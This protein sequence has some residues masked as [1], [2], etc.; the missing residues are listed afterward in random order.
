M[1]AGR[2]AAGSAKETPV[3]SHRS[4]S[5][6]SLALT[7]VPLAL[8]GCSAAGTDSSKTTN[9]GNGNSSGSGNS[10]S[11]T[12]GSGPGVGMPMLNDDDIN[13]EEMPSTCGQVLPVLYR[14]F[15]AYGQPGGHDDFEAS[16][17]GIHNQ[18]GGIY[19]G[20][21]DVGCGLVEPALGTDG[22]PVAFAGTPD[23]VEAMPVVPAGTGKRRR[24]VS[25]AGC[26]TAANP[27]P[28]GICGIGTCVP[29]DISPITYAIKSSSTFAQWYNTTAGINMEVPGELMLTQDPAAPG[30]SFFD[31]TAFFPIDNKGFGN[32][33]GQQHNYHFTTEIHVKFKYEVGQKFTFR[34]D[35]DLWIF[36]NGKLALD[37][38]GQ[39]Q[40]LEGTID[41]DAQALTL[42]I[43]AGQSYPMDIFH[44]ERQTDQSNFRIQ[45]NIKC[46]ERVPVK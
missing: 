1:T 10:G 31:S 3:L 32:T 13:M 20:W 37:V 9:P 6:L 46:F 29:W 42:G 23:K 17:R 30:T 28:T 7:V 16:A 38:G 24:L 25:G 14:D 40:A 33:A 15:N 8:F 34:G 45:T 18:D 44:A 43:T 36:V 2:Y 21:N 5:A 4:L 41:F 22:K 26:F 19:M 12:S 27:K 39:H 11:G 35:D